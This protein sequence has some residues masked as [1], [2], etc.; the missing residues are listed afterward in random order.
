MAWAPLMSIPVAP[1][2]KNHHSPGTKYYVRLPGQSTIMEA[3][4]QASDLKG[5]P[6]NSLRTRVARPNASHD[7]GRRQCG[8]SVSP[9]LSMHLNVVSE[10]FRVQLTK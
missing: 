4:A 7:L 6:H 10:I 8:A 3:M 9:R 5:S 1:M 2:H